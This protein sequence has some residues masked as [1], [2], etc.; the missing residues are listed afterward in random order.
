MKNFTIIAALFL[1]AGCASHSEN[2]SVINIDGTWKG[3]MK[4][5]FGGQPMY[6]TFNFKK[7]GDIVK[8]TVNGMP[9]K[10]IPLENLEMKGKK[11][12]FSVT[13]EMYGMK[14]VI[15]YTGKIKGEKIDMSFKNESPGGGM[16]GG[17]GGGGRGPRVTNTKSIGGSGMG[18]GFG[19]GGPAPSNKFTLER[20]SNEPQNPVE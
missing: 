19:M 12:T 14:S 8:G 1:I 20:V 13:S 7:V 4:G 15:N 3:E 18:G 10:W 16:G 6:F 17:F 5:G 9:G 11:I 2:P